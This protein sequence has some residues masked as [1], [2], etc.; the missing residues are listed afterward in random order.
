MNRHEEIS[1]RE[2]ILKAGAGAGVIIALL[3]GLRWRAVEDDKEAKKE[4]LE[5]QRLV[6]EMPAPEITPEISAFTDE[7]T[8]IFPEDNLTLELIR[9]GKFDV[10][11]QTFE[12][13]RY[14]IVF[15]AGDSVD[16]TLNTEDKLEQLYGFVL[17]T[18]AK[19]GMPDMIGITEQAR[20][21][22]Q[23]PGWTLDR[24]LIIPQ[25]QPGNIVGVA[26]RGRFN[27][28]QDGENLM[29]MVGSSINLYKHSTAVDRDGLY[30]NTDTESAYYR[31]PFVFDASSPMEQAPQFPR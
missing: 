26:L 30:F 14:H 15:N 25:R 9:N 5:Y 2:V 12:L 22:Q 13:D 20:R 24:P 4:L 3:G 29:L 27:S 18:N 23:D 31:A 1:R 21:L 7:M 8:A 6:S 17:E 11:S 28:R 10:N 19:A 16:Y